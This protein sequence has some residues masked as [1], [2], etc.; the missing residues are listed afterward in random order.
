MFMIAYFSTRSYMEK[1]HAHILRA[2][3]R[4]IVGGFLFFVIVLIAALW[5][6]PGMPYMV[7]TLL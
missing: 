1:H 5:A 6:L 3:L 4:R 2:V 7:F